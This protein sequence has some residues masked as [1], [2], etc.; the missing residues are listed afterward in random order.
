MKQPIKT[1]MLIAVLSGLT[2][3]T[4][5]QLVVWSTTNFVDDPVG[6]YGTT[7]DF[8]GSANPILNIVDPGMG[9]PGTHAMELTFDATSGTV[10]NFQ[11]AGIYYPASGNTNSFLA[12]YTLEFDLAVLG[13]D[14]GPFAQGFQISI[15]GPGGGVFGTGPKLELDLTTNTFP[16]GQGYQHYS[17]T[18]DKFTARNFLVTSNSFELGI[19]C[20]SYPGNFTA[21][22]ETFDFANIQITLKTNPPPPPQPTLTVLPA[23]PGLRVFGQNYA[24][25]YN[26]EGFGTVDPNQSWVGATP[27]APKS[28]SITIKDFDTVDNYT[29]YS[30]FVSS[31]PSVNPFVVYSSPNA[32]VWSITHL[33]TGFT[34]SVNWKTNA[35]NSGTPNNTLNLTTASLNGRGTWTLS[36]TNDTDGTVIAPDGT[37]GSFTLPPDVATL[38]ADPLTILFGTAPNN[39]GG[40]GQWVD[41]SRITITNVAG[42][43]EDDDFTKDDGLNTSL[44]D[45]GFSLDPGSVIQVSTNTPFWVRWNVP[46]QGFG[47]GTKASLKGG[48]NQWF[49]PNYYGGGTFTNTTPT[50][51]GPAL[52][53]TLL[54]S[55]CLPTMDGTVNGPPSPQGFFR[56]SSPPP[57]Q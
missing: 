50:Q 17:F 32:L 6:P 2:A 31:A 51:M 36:F 44:W 55:A 41:I 35:P 21:A 57:G 39:T 12:N 37:S 29:L 38:F 26:Q 47:L 5:A 10:I 20:V 49:T 28:Y 11:S 9:G 23:K 19:G 4:H 45:P 30:Q 27:G 16:A 25:T 42:V 34:T 52:K 7:T 8:A 18:L 46:D 13:V 14:A 33:S 53:W 54:P 22:P 40:F 1:L 15:F 3:A 56:L 24:F 43:I 48:T